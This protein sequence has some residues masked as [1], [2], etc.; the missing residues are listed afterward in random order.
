MKRAPLRPAAVAAMPRG[1]AEIRRARPHAR[2]DLAHTAHQR[3]MFILRH[4]LM[5]NNVA[6]HPS[7]SIGFVVNKTGNVD[8]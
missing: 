3:S 1:L 8:V 7:T 6:Y 2:E 5:A 4:S